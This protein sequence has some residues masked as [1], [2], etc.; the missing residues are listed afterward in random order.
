M[1]LPSEVPAVI[2]EIHHQE[3]RLDA[4]L[5]VRIRAHDAA[6]RRSREG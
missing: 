6:V 1:A 5:K 4:E 2:A 3:R